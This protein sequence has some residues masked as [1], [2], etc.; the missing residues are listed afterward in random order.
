M[1]GTHILS[2]EMTVAVLLV[3]C[4]SLM[5]LT[6]RKNTLK[7]Y[8][9]A[10][11][12]SCEVSSYFL[13]PFL[14]YSINVPSKISAT[15]EKN[16]LD[17]QKRGMDVAEYFT[18]F[19]DIHH[20]GTEFAKERMLL[21]PGI[22]L[23]ATLIAAIALLLNNQGN[24]I[25]RALVMYACLT[26]AL[27]LNIFPWDYLSSKSRL[28]N[29]A[30]QVQFPWRYVSMVTIILTLL[31]GELLM[32]VEDGTKQKL[33]MGIITTVNCLMACYL[34]G[35]Y[36]DGGVFK[37]LYD[38]AEL[39]SYSV[40]TGEYLRAGTNRELFPTYKTDVYS[41]NMREAVIVD[42]NSTDMMLYCTA[43]E[44]EEGLMWLPLFNYKGYHVTDEKGNE[45]P[46]KDNYNNQIE[47]SVP[48]G[49]EGYI[50]VEFK[51]PWYWRL[52]EAIS[53][54]SVFGFGMKQIGA[55]GSFKGM[56]GRRLKKI[57]HV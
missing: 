36:I 6:F 41:E 32:Q 15:M 30:A 10:V 43:S 28:V 57:K 3:V 1:I 4:L 29:M 16:G 18:F 5:K 54:I 25:V 40:S 11:L 49:F 47:I 26:V 13:V 55:R 19:R 50:Q 9:W 8:I 45:Y 48:A 46:I 35:N 31:L 39:S 52:S 33:F 51:E 53:L 2:T 24:K 37:Y 27:T 7:V 21:S 17:I 20:D 56:L 12:G 42:R 23:V 22:V 44:Q 34:L 38:G 14:D